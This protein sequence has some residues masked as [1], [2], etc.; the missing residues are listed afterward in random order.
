MHFLAPPP[1]C[2]WQLTGRLALPAVGR[3][4][5]RAANHCVPLAAAG[6]QPEWQTCH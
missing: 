5:L 6:C 3:C 1:H 2:Q 4:V